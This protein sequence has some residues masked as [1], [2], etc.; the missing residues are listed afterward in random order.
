L[1]SRPGQSLTGL[2]LAL[3]GIPLYLGFGR[4]SRLEKDA[5]L[6]TAALTPSAAIPGTGHPAD[7]G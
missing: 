2:G 5:E 1:F 6:A 3:L 4:R 7:R